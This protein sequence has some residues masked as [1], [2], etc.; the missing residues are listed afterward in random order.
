MGQAE[1]LFLA[2]VGHMETEGRSVTDRFSDVVRVGPHDDADFGDAGFRYG[3]QR[4]EEDRFV[5]DWN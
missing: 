3:F 2:D 5:G 1:G 4:I